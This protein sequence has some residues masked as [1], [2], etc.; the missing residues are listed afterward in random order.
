M[1][2][3]FHV[4]ENQ[5]CSFEWEDDYSIKA[6]PPK[7]CPKCLKQTA[8]R[9]ISLC[10]KGVVELVG[11]EI[12]KKTEED[13]RKLKSDMHRS[14]KMYANLLGEDRYQRMQTQIDKRRR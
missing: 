12:T 11:E 5:E 10:G 7:D 1:P 13:V 8:K 4:C 9:M 2:T 6:E 14:E 3:Y